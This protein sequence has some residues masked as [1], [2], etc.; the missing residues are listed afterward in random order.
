MPNRLKGTCM[1]EKAED[2][3]KQ[4][5]FEDES[6]IY[7]IEKPLL[8]EASAGS[9]KTTVLVERYLA[10]ILFQYFHGKKSHYES[11][12]SVVAV[13]FTRKAASEMKD[14][15]R[16]RIRDHFNA[17]YLETVIAKLEKY[18]GI[19][20]E[21]PSEAVRK[22]LE[23]SDD[24]LQAVISAPIST[25]HSFAL[26][27]LR[28]YPV[29]SG[30]DPFAS[31]QDETGIEDLS[32]TSADALTGSL[33][34]MIRI[35]NSDL[36][37]MIRIQGYELVR[38][39]IK[40]LDKAVS[41]TGI[42]I[43]EGALRE[44]GFLDFENV[45]DPGEQIRKTVLPVLNSIL[46]RLDDL[47]EKVPARSK[48]P[49]QRTAEKIRKF[50][51]K[52]V[53]EDIFRDDLWY[54]GTLQD[55]LE[56]VLP[57]YERVFREKVKLFFPF[58]WRVYRNYWKTSEKLKVSRKE[59][60][61]SDIEIK[62]LEMLRTNR[63]IREKISGEIRYILVDEYQDTS[64]LQKEIFD[65]LIRGGGTGTKRSNGIVP[66]M[67]GDPKQSIFGFRNA[68]LEVFYETR[69]EIGAD[70][71]KRLNRNY[72][73]TPKLVEDINSIFSCIFRDSGPRI[74]YQDQEA[75][76]V[77]ARG[78]VTGAFFLPAVREEGKKVFE[79]SALQ[80]SRLIH[81]LVSEKGYAPGEIM[82]LL[83]KKTN[84][85]AL[86]TAFDE[87]LTPSGIH[88]YIVEDI[89]D[90]MQN[91]EIRDLVIYLRALENRESD[92]YFLALLKTPFFRKSDPEILAL[93]KDPGIG[94]YETAN[95]AV[96]EEMRVF[97]ALYQVKNRLVIPELAE[98]IVTRTGYFAY[99]NS[100]PGRKEATTNLIVFLDFLRKIQDV[101][102]FSLTDFLYY[103]QEYSVSPRPPQVVGEK[104]DVVRVMT[105]H[106]AKG[107]QARAVVYIAPYRK[108]DTEKIRM[109]VRKR[110]GRY[111]V[112]LNL[113]ERISRRRSDPM[114]EYLAD[115][116]DEE[117]KRL[118][119]VALTRAEELFYYFGIIPEGVDAKNDFWSDFIRLEE[120]CFSARVA[121]HDGI[122][123]DTDGFY[124]GT[125]ARSDR[126]EVLAKL[127][128]LKGKEKTFAYG[129]YPR[130]LTITQLL[131]IE[132]IGE[133][134]RNRYITRSFPVE[135]ALNEIADL[136]DVLNES[137]PNADIGTYLHRVFQECDADNFEDYI[138][139]TIGLEN[140][141]IR[142]N[143]Q[144]I[145]VLSGK[146]YRSGF[147]KGLYSDNASALK[148][149]EINY[150]APY[151]PD[152][153]LIKGSIDLYVKKKGKGVLVDYKLTMPEDRSRYERQL[154]YYAHILGE[155][156]YPVDEMFLYDILSN[157]EVRVEK[158]KENIGGLLAENIGKIAGIYLQATL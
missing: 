73:S 61:F 139:K 28:A 12:R 124:R 87:N 43:L 3:R 78:P 154:H 92:H 15:I 86:K 49:V 1:I 89:A 149:F 30:I 26:S 152:T 42:P 34:E 151:G 106:M 131:D 8:L 14:R 142:S 74:V 102:M 156:G 77:G 32:I 58:L 94:L 75:A 85:N 113:F 91:R 117:E 67:V 53:M 41:G 138:E 97:N 109:L 48:A 115:M 46:E 114:K 128:Y 137:N 23:T 36:A 107:L 143:R 135:E 127:D 64:D 123:A 90:I 69:R 146:Y 24:L 25:I 5:D 70:G 33:R 11:V 132:F 44:E 76:G 54:D 140:E 155:L 65:L 157:S 147:Y 88:Y 111:G 22:L 35:R 104:S 126:K 79:Y 4:K 120:P 57:L 13:T 50:I 158:S 118:A 10:S 130:I 40:E 145:L 96:S 95:R 101:E 39:M 144:K 133:G 47:R 148:E 9:G 6:V 20:I 93:R 52:N 110:E 55:V 99:L 71:Y 141:T 84:M 45:K 80:A 63:S 17:S 153:V 59:I 2:T 62:F 103:L 29:E 116:Q 72:R 19:K 81:R 105:V 122:R 108:T 112:F 100:L 150:N 51:A 136:T 31:T 68:N 56:V 60:S 119:Y 129:R 27:Y 66:F 134:F 83:R 18:N 21:K 7:S 37:W 16:S 121:G 82:V 125:S 98:E 38:E